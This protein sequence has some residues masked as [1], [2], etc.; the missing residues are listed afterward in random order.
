MADFVRREV[1]PL[2]LGVDV[3]RVE[4]LVGELEIAVEAR[5]FDE[6]TSEEVYDALVSAGYGDA[7]ATRRTGEIAVA[8]G[9]ARWDDD[10]AQAAA[11]PVVDDRPFRI[12]GACAVAFVAAVAAM[13]R[14]ESGRGIALIAEHWTTG[15]TLVVLVPVFHGLRG[16]TIGGGDD[17]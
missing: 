10:D 15:L 1:E 7:A 11:P 6:D 13:L 17:D 4:M 8:L 2:L 5:A 16:Q 3:A 14:M 9:L 12:Y